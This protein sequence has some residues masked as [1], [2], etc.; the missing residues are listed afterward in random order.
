MQLDNA[1]AFVQAHGSPVEQARLQRVLD[2][3][4]AA[5]DVVAALLD[6]QRSDGGWPPFWAPDYSSLDA[7]CYR[8]AQAE[9]LGVPRGRP[10][11]QRA[12]GCLAQRQAA[13]GWWEEEAA[14]VSH[15]PPWAK[16]GDLAARLYLTANCGLWLAAL[17][18][19][20]GGAAHAAAYL[21]RRLDADGRLP[22]F[23]HT[24]WLAAGLWQRLGWAEPRDRVLTYLCSRVN[25]LP[26][27]SLAW[28]LT[29][30]LSAGVDPQRPVVVKATARLE[31]HQEVD[32]RW[33]SEDS[34]A[35]DVHA[36]LEALRALRLA[37]LLSYN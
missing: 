31:R 14:V 5:P 16:P 27:G 9:A 28:L 35:R 17:K 36:T 33:Q 15:A 30:L 1:I 13:D 6:G 3:H 29:T 7:T 2:G 21:Q 25:E 37:G 10:A 34:P 11:I 22:G 4:P 8:L 23:L 19:R 24:H 32:G 18:R 20:A 26:P 12:V